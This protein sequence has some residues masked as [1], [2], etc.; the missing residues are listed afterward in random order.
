MKISSQ[1]IKKHLRHGGKVTLKAKLDGPPSILC[2]LPCSSAFGGEDTPKFPYYIYREITEEIIQGRVELDK[3]DGTKEIK[4]EWISISKPQVKNYEEGELVVAINEDEK[5]IYSIEKVR[6]IDNENG[7]PQN[8]YLEEVKGIETAI[9]PHSLLR[10]A[11]EEEKENV[12]IEHFITRDE[13]GA[14][15]CES[16]DKKFKKL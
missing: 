3:G 13:N 15:S 8:Y 1:K 16:C 2:F 5:T 6:E 4:Y 9:K 7:W 11:T 10:L 12:N 14:W